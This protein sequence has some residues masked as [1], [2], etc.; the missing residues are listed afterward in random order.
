MMDRNG[1]LFTWPKQKLKLGRYIELNDNRL[2]LN[3]I[4]NVMPTFFTFPI[5]YVSY[6]TALRITPP[7]RKKLPFVL[8]KAKK[9]INLQ[10]LKKRI[11]DKTNLQALTQNEFAWRSISYVLE[12]T[13]IPINFGIT[14]TLGIIIGAAIT[15]QTFYIFVIENLKQFAAMKAIGVTNKQLFKMVLLQAAVIGLI[16]Y[17]I[18]TGLTALFFQITKDTPALQGFRLHWEIM[19][20]TF[21]V[22]LVVILFS[23]IFSLRKVFKL[24]PAIVFRG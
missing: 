9:G 16:G 7:A 8:V 23:I 15:A 24:D 17:S 3:A 4:C 21:C 1:Y 19:L 18:G 2:I 14:I 11:T 13:G 5:L 12:R 22:I 6:N 10:I 20:G